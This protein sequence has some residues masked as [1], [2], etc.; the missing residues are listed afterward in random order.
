MGMWVNLG[1]EAFR[2]IRN[3]CY[4]DKTGLI[5]YMNSLIGTS[6]PLVCFARPRRF[7]KSF[8]ARM[9][10]AYYD[11]SCQSEELFQGLEISRKKSFHEYLNQFHVIYIDMTWFLSTV[12]DKKRIVDVLQ[13]SVTGELKVLFPGAVRE[14]ESS[15]PQ[16]LVAISQTYGEKFF[17]IIDEYDALFREEKDD[18]I[19]QMEFIQFLRAMFKSGPAMQSAI[20]GAFMTGILPVKKYG[21][22]SAVSDFREYTMTSPAKLAR[23]IGFTEREVKRLCRKFRMDFETVSAW[24][25]GY[26]FSRTG[27]VYCPNSVMNAMQDEEIQNYWT[28]TES[29][30]SLKRYIDENYDGL[31]DAIVL[32]LGGQRV[33][34]D[35]STFQN[36]I[37]SFGNKDD[38]L[39]LLVYL[40]YL[41][42]DQGKKE[43][44]IPNREVAEVFQSA[45]KGGKWTAVEEAINESEKLLDAT[46]RCDSETVASSLELVHA[47]CASV[48]KYNDENSLAC[49]IYIAYYTARNYYMIIRELPSGKGFADY[50]FIPRH[51]TDKPAMIIELKYDKNADTAIS[52]IHDNRYDGALKDYFGEKLLV[53]IDYNRDAKGKNAKKHSCVIEKA[54]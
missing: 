25:D 43:V 38:V 10:A 1:N 42:Y 27:H 29:F 26:S 22:E 2:L 8:S 54:K 41:A 9:L 48:L 33:K 11:K 52:Q 5:D 19:L 31:K 45:T 53:G 18:K 16:A 49:A 14:E 47:E 34:I 12:K 23:Y 35:I 46:I 6:R 50:A 13:T 4:V 17:I 20:A 15:L 7:G 21:S 30:E 32:M 28:K 40:G 3:D 36:D 51:G 39:T 44:Y 37:T 24:Y